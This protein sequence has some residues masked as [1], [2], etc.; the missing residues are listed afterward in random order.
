[1][2]V[3]NVSFLNPK[4][5][6][7]TGGTSVS[8]LG[9]QLTI[10]EQELGKDGY[11]S[12]GDYD[13]LIN[14]AR[15]IQTTPGL[16]AA[17]RSDYDVKI[18]RFEKGKETSQIDKA[19]DL[20][21]ME[22]TLKGEAAEDV[23][24]VGN[25]PAEFIRGRIASLQSKLNDLQEIITRRQI[26]SQDSTEYENEYSAALSDYQEKMNALAA[27]ESF[28][29]NNPVLGYAAFVTTNS[30]GEI[31]DVDYG[32]HGSKQGYAETNGMIDGFQIYGK[33]N[34]KRDG[35]NFFAL[36]NNVFQAPDMLTP[37]PDNPGSFK[38]NKLVANVTQRG[39]ISI[40]EAGYVNIPG[41]SVKIQSYIPYDSWAKGVGGTVYKR[42]N[43]G[44]YTR[45]ININQSLPDMPNPDEM[46]TLPQSF[47][48]KIMRNADETIDVSAPI[49][50]DAG[51]NYTPMDQNVFN[52]N[53]FGG[54]Q[55]PQSMA[56]PA[57]GEPALP[58]SMAP[59]TPVQGNQ[60]TQARR[61]PQQPTQ[62]ASTSFGSTISRTVRSGVDYLKNLFR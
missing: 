24:M 31:I 27:M 48:Q 38:P 33:I 1:M 36:G 5:R 51:L 6:V 17:Q 12:P 45:Y 46:L 21:R 39:P 54:Q 50:P 43:D 4:T 59:Q 23:M 8:I 3:F 29:G 32:R 40:G 60:S 35:K 30:N 20:D 7:K 9:D 52:Q 42:R 28:D 61:T 53:I 62:Q 15:E 44:G 2:P 25:N 58:M 13:L 14:K 10:L 18:S 34:F 11:L 49:E 41:D 56:Q 26:S 22:N 19:E 55:F 37:D 16:T 57:A 47:E